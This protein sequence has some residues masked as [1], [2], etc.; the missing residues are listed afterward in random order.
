M[1]K[2]QQLMGIKIGKG[3]TGADNTRLHTQDQPTGRDLTVPPSNELRVVLLGKTGSGKS[4]LGNTLLGRDEFQVTQ[5]MMSGIEKCQWGQTERDGVV[6][7]VTDTPGLC[8]MDRN[9]EDILGEVAKCVAVTSP[10]P[11]IV[12]MVLRCGKRFT[13]EECESYRTLKNLFGAEIRTHMIVVFSGI[14]TRPGTA[15]EQRAGLKMELER[16]PPNLKQ[17][18]IR[19]ADNR[20]F[21]V[22]NVSSREERDAQAEMLII[23]MKELMHMNG[24]LFLNSK[25][26]QE[27][28]AHVQ[29]FS[30]LAEPGAPPNIQREIVHGNNVEFERGLTVLFIRRLYRLFRIEGSRGRCSLM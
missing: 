15:D 18:V 17:V 7:Q 30:P 12:L 3:T 11:H 6:L 22:N 9:D 4:S 8:D 27:I 13:Q 25:V 28:S 1:T 20:F 26:N 10:G 2:V 29:K 21:G 24:G 19:D 14:D 16:A 23:K 5:G